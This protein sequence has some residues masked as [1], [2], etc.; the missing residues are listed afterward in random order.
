VLFVG[1]F[2]NLAN[3]AGDQQQEHDDPSGL[4]QLAP[5]L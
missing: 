5:H 4:F 2:G 1:G 3:K